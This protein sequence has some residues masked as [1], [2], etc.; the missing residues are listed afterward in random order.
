MMF[1]AVLRWLP[2]QS[3]RFPRGAESAP[4]LLMTTPST[5]SRSRHLETE[6]HHFDCMREG[7]MQLCICHSCFMPL[8]RSRRVSCRK[9]LARHYS[10]RKNFGPGP[11]SCVVDPVKVLLLFSLITMQ[12]LVAVCHTV[13]A[14]AE[15]CKKFGALGSCPLRWGCP[16]P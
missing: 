4:M 6:L 15:G 9:R 7:T 2:G 16:T 3:S 11:G 12:N 10:C 13:W 14:Y 8:F 1:A 5:A